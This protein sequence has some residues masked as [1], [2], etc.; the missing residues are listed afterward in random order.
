MSAVVEGDGSGLTPLSRLLVAHG[1]GA[2]GR[3]LAL[4]FALDARL[5]ELVR[6][7]SEPMI[8][9]IR[10]AWWR[11]A[12]GVVES[13]RVEGAAGRGDPLVDALTPVF[14]VAADRA[15]LGAM[16]DGWE[17]LIDPADP[18]DARLAAFAE[19]RGG[20][21]ALVAGD[22][23]PSWVG[24]A[25]AG[26]ALWDMAGHVRDAGLA[27]RAMALAGDRLA[28]APVRGWSGRLAPL[29]LMTG[30]AR[31]DAVAGRVPTSGLTP[32]L[33]RRFLWLALLRKG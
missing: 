17:E 29:R 23:A 6:S 15:A 22:A 5:A 26:W 3:R 11:E 7:T 20:L 2:V 16:I 31:A 24:A 27:R 21:F 25:G 28:Q 12:L 4:A 8:G 33:Y 18:G 30:L 1:R 13:K 9:A 10:M 14:A 19:G 32:A